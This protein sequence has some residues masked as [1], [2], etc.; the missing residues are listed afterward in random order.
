MNFPLM[1]IKIG[2]HIQSVKHFLGPKHQEI[3]I[4]FPQKSGSYQ[5][6]FIIKSNNFIQNY[7]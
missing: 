5:E 1:Q 3:R 6:F 4:F 7:K 2:L